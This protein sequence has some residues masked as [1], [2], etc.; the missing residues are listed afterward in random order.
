MIRLAKVSGSSK[1][2][3]R[4]L[5][6]RLDKYDASIDFNAWVVTVKLGDKVFKLKLLHC[7][8]YLEKFKGREW[9]ELVVK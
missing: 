3:L 6:A 8:S 2:I 7:R 4:K 9:Y 1:P 5:S